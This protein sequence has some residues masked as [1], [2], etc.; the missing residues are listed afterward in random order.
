MSNNIEKQSSDDLITQDYQN[1]VLAQ[2][3]NLIVDIA[4]EIAKK[5]EEDE[6][7][8]SAWNVGVRKTCGYLWYLA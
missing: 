6:R 8:K 4:K 3:Q 1:Y 7:S 5:G 2:I